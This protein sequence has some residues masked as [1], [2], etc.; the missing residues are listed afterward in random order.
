M[1]KIGFLVA[2]LPFL[3]PLNGI[4]IPI[5]TYNT[6]IDHL[7]TIFLS[8]M[9]IIT[10]IASKKKIVVDTN[11]RL[12]SLYFLVSILSSYFN[13]PFSE[14]SILQTINYSTVFLIYFVIINTIDS[15]EKFDYFYNKFILAGVFSIIYGLILFSYSVFFGQV[16]GVNLDTYSAFGIY[17][18][19]REPNIFGSFCVI[20]FTMLF[21]NFLYRHLHKTENLNNSIYFLVIATLGV[22]LSFTRSAWLSIIVVVILSNFVSSMKFKLSSNL[23]R[24]IAI[25]IP[26]V[27]LSA[28]I[29]NDISSK[30][31]FLYKLNNIIN[32]E[33]E[34]AYGRV[35]LW[36]KAIDSFLFHPMIGN[37]TF[38][39]AALGNS[40]VLNKTTNLWIGNLYIRLLHDSG[41]IGTIIFLLCFILTMRKGLFHFN[42]LAKNGEVKNSSEIFG[43]ILSIITILIAFTFTDATTY[44]Y[45]YLPLSLL[46]AKNYIISKKE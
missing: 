6:R 39:F 44:C 17:G 37:G 14:Y 40:G 28:F 12:F 36:E 25:I 11:L 2:I 13:A 1:K 29:F 22:L 27:F 35:M 21:N 18:T 23:F 26:I 16:Q 20:I 32:P 41:L 33:S 30:G 15:S 42:Q 46:A 10:K 31:F 43:L 24:M 38:S 8:F 3:L 4:D 7:W 9:I 45:G 34:T 5:G 19:M